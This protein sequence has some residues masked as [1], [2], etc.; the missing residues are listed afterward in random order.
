MTRSFAGCA[1]LLACVAVAGCAG[2]GK[3]QPAASGGKASQVQVYNTTQLV[4]SQ[5]TVVQRLWIDGWR[6][7]LTYPTY[8]SVENG[9]EAMRE[10]AADAGANGLLNVMCMDATGYSKGR[11]LCYGDAIKFN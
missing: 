9:I 5:Y 4:P 7:N 6:S 8:R 2:S 3:K 1:V 10:K 11:L